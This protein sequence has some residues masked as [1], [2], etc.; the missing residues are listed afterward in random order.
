MPTWHNLS[1]I[2]SLCKLSGFW[3]CFSV[4]TH[5][6]L[7]TCT[8]CIVHLCRRRGLS[9]HI[10]GIS[11]KCLNISVTRATKRC[12]LLCKLCH[13]QC[14]KLPL[15]KTVQLQVAPTFASVTMCKFFRHI[16]QPLRCDNWSIWCVLLARQT[17]QWCQWPIFLLK[18]QQIDTLPIAML[19]NMSI[20]LLGCQVTKC[21]LCV[22]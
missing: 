2:V 9:R 13:H 1:Y 19:A 4:L 16:F 22:G 20:F 18:L 12:Q 11:D 8:M 10:S 17:F 14:L 3:N 15:C 7:C 21:S 5:L 6:S